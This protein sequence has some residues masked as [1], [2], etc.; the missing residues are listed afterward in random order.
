MT[1]CGGEFQSP[2]WTERWGV[3]EVDEQSGLDRKWYFRR[4]DRRPSQWKT[5]GVDRE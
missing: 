1:V 4:T 3:E 5:S 2:E